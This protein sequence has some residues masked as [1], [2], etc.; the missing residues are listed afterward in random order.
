MTGFDFA[1][2]LGRGCA[3]SLV[4]LLIVY[5]LLELVL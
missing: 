2:E 1:L 5:C 4:S 3:L